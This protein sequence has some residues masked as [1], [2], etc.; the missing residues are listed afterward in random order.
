MQN[1]ELSAQG[2]HTDCAVGIVGLFG[3][4]DSGMDTITTEGQTGSRHHLYIIFLRVAK[5]CHWITTFLANSS[6][7]GEKAGQGSP[8]G[9]AIWVLSGFIPT[10]LVQTS[11][12][13]CIVLGSWRQSTLD[14][15][16]A[17]GGVY[18]Y[19]APRQNNFPTSVEQYTERPTT[20]PWVFK[21]KLD[22]EVR[23]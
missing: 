17:A 1:S 2:Q 11:V 18:P 9:C 7:V 4:A 10:W 8:S 3:G 6:S 23:R 15:D 16:K 20:L 14:V 22:T 5:T 12:P 19:L 13:C 21:V